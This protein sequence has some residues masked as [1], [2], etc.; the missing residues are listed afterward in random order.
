MLV[1]ID[2]A[3]NVCPQEPADALTAL[4]TEHAISIAAEGRKFGIYLLV[5]TQR[6]QKV[7]ENVLSQ[8]DNLILMRICARPTSTRCSLRSSNRRMPWTRPTRSRA[9]QG[10]DVLMLGPGDSER[11]G[12][13]S[14]P[15]RP[16]DHQRRYRRVAAAA[17]SA[18]KWWGTVSGGPEHTQML[19]DLGAM[20]ICHGC[21][22]LMV[23]QGHGTD[24]EDVR[25]AGLHVRQSTGRRGGR[26]GSARLGTRHYGH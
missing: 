7:H 20:F 2:E 22:L 17:K 23:K 12:R 25:G 10:I 5:A 8:S 3:H 6:P 19:L 21:D 4:A 15:V 11:L 9:C 24:S 13:H 26:L 1:V 14:L 16:S 18:G